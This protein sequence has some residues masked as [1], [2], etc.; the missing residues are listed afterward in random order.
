MEIQKYHRRTVILTWVGARDTC[1]SKN[2]D[3]LGRWFSPPMTIIMLI[4]VV[5]SSTIFF[6]AADLSYLTKPNVS[7]RVNL[8][9]YADWTSV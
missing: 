3:V 9:F 4:F 8:S 2:K 1:L 7:F 5:F 6:R